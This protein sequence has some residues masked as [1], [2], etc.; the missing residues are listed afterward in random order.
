MTTF[1][2]SLPKP[3]TR[4]ISFYDHVTVETPLGE[5]K[6][7]W[8]SWKSDPSYDI[9]LHGDWIG[10]EYDLDD[11]KLFAY[12]YIKQKRNELNQFLNEY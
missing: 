8:K 1:N 9:M 2:W 4:D 10:V 11:A 7:E 6:I 5:L 12:N 3:P